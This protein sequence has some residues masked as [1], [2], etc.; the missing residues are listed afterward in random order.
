LENTP[1]EVHNFYQ[2][3]CGFSE[4]NLVGLHSQNIIEV[5]ISRFSHQ[6]SIF[7]FMHNFKLDLI[8]GE[9]LNMGFPSH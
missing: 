4:L 5:A 1:K 7:W 9:D 3:T 6:A 2:F 8:G